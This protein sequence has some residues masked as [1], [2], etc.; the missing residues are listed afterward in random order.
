MSHDQTRRANLLTV[1][2]VSGLTGCLSASS[3]PSNTSAAEE[4][5]ATN[6]P[7]LAVRDNRFV[8][9][10]GDAVTLRG[11][12]ITDPK[13]AATT[14]HRGRTSSE[15]V[16]HLTDADAGWYPSVIRIPVQPIDIGDH[17]HG[18]APTPP[19]FT[20]AE[21]EAYLTT[22]LDPLICQCAEQNVYAIIDFHRD[23]QAI[24]WGSA[25]E[26]TINNELQAEATTFWESVAGR[27]GGSDHVLFEVYNEPTEPGM[28]G[29]TSDPQTQAIWQLFL[30]FVQP[31]V[32]TI[33][34]RSDAIAI[35]GSPGWSSSPEG[36]LIEPVT[37]GNIAYSYH[38][39]PGHDVSAAHAW[40]GKTDDGGGVEAMYESYPLFVTEFGWR[41]YDDPWL[42]GTTSGFGEPFMR[43]IESHDAI[44]W[45]AWCADVW[46]DP[47][48]FVQD[49]ET[50][51]WLLRGRDGG[52][53][54]DAG[55]YIR[56]QL[57]TAA[58]DTR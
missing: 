44:N 32:D 50:G 5:P 18:T 6:L 46:W 17:K 8:T 55:E 15:M 14:P 23:G 57:A 1:L 42:G 20:T 36:A 9:P 58:D 48:M 22:Y 21:L 3:P 52:S 7:Q 37:G 40:D 39:Y 19:A 13:R 26:N 4:T 28:W 56:Q 54:E 49:T 11:V 27:Y 12:S 34:E 38:V 53:D 10:N 35:V 31:I 47:A 25:S 30:K 24:Q 43:W 29:P 45:T 51:E 41:D 2:G 16:A 33:R